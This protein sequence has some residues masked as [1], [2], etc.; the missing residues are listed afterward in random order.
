MRKLK[1]QIQISLDGFVAGP[2]GELDWMSQEMA[3]EQLQVLQE[4]TDGM[5]TILMGRKMVGGFTGYWE[6]VVDNQPDSP[7]YAYARIFVDT[8]KIVFSK[9][10]QQVKGKNVTV[11]NGDIVSKVNALKQQPGKDIIVYGGASFVA[12][13]IKNNLIDELNL[14]VNPVA[15]GNGL[16]IFN[17]RFNFKLAQS[18]ACA[19]GIVINRY[20]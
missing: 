12:S 3:P 11:E 2:T 8:P 4:L 18:I 1:L 6:H 15:I 5:D 14:F 17:D 16:K 7:E 9:T 20:V 10:V 13:L 19:N